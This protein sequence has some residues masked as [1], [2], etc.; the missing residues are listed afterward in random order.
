MNLNS[1]MRREAQAMLDEIQGTRL[2][3]VSAY[4]PENYSVKVRL[5]PEGN[6]TGWIPIQ[7]TAIG[8]GWG[9]YFPPEINDQAVVLFQ[10]GNLDSGICIGFL[11]SDADRPL[12][13]QSGE[14]WM[15][16]KSGVR[17]LFQDGRL[18][19]RGDL[20]EVGGL[21]SMVRKLIDQ[22]F[23]ELFNN[24]THPGNNLPPNQKITNDHMTTNLRGA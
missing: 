6:E 4:N 8:N 14:W 24:H 10:E 18:Q 1:A 19:L 20:I 2:A 9:L 23:Q 3:E 5:Q 22:R 7:S 13:V 16:H 11:Y 15:V 21:G 12:S 17:I